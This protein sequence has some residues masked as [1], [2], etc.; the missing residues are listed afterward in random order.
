MKKSFFTFLLIPL[1]LSCAHNDKKQD[2][3]NSVAPKIKKEVMEYAS[4]YVNGKLKDPVKTVAPDGAITIGEN[5]TSYI[6]DPAKISAGLIDD[7]NSVDAIVSID[8][9]HGQYLVLTEHLI[10]INTEGKL[11]LNRVIES[12]MK[13]LGIKDR[14]ITAEVYTKSRNSPLSDCSLCK[15]V[16]KYRFKSGDLI[17]V[18]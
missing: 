6:I 2:A 15:E 14:V 10:L 1:L 9:Y 7:D 16:V 12:D 11:T 13:I 5:Q 4:N 3:G 18:E 8:Y 17:K